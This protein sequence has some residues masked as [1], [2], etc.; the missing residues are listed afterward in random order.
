MNLDPSAFVADSEL[1]AAL[2]KIASPVDCTEDRVLFAQG[3]PAT[4]LYVLRAGKGLLTMTS[5][6][7]EAVVATSVGP[8]TLLGLPGVI[9]NQPYSLTGVV[10]K[11]A[12]V[13]YV[14][15]EEFSQL[16]LREPSLSLRVLRVLA[17]EVRTARV[18][19]SHA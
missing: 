14:P 19:I 12:E 5:E 13:G 18:A 2:E 6:R 8:G 3:E 11:G 16:M 1:L 10:L 7:G 17:A 4:G 15:R 9:G